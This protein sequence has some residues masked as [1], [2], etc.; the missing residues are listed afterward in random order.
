MK[1]SKKQLIKAAKY[2]GAIALVFP[3]ISLIFY[4]VSLAPA[5]I[6]FGAILGLITFPFFTY[7]FR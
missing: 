7:H 6:A 1:L 2:S 3:A 5:P 4:I